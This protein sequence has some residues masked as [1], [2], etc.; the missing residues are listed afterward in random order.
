MP[1]SNSGLFKRKKYPPGSFV[2]MKRRPKR[3]EDSD[4]SDF[5]PPTDYDSDNH[6]IVPRT[7]GKRLLW[8]VEDEQMLM[9]R[10][11]GS[12]RRGVLSVADL[13][14]AP[15]V[16]NKLLAKGFTEKKIMDKMQALKTRVA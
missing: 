10:F 8:E 4:D 9:D 13:R 5:I 11:R 6:V 7:K 15:D 3:A 16:L 2:M 12:M 14:G 1:V